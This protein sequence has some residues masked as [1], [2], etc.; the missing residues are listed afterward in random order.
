VRRL[1]SSPRKRRRAAWAGVLL[2][3][4]GC[5]VLIGFLWPNTG[6][7]EA[8]F[9][10]GKPKIV[11]EEPPS[12]PL[13]KADLAS[14]RKV[15]DVFVAE[16][17]L[18]QHLDRA[19]DIVTPQ[20]RQGMTRIEWKTQDNP[21]IPFPVRDFVLAKSKL[22]YSHGNIARYDVAMLARPQGQTA[23]GIFSIELHALGR[24][25][26]RHWL[27][28][29]W[30]PIGGGISTPAV[31]RANPLALRNQT[32]ATAQPLS[33]SWVLVPLAVLSLIVLLPVGLGVRGWVRNRRI[34]RAYE[35]KTLPPLKK[36][37]GS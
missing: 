37:T 6:T 3:A 12:S 18:R 24:D 33:T 36:P 16:A 27:V 13:S 26:R 7:K 4:A 1:L 20:M 11:H 34:N 32:S 21:V 23:S 29:Y 22:S 10:P 30:Q 14:S 35:A 31:P 5:A 17:V 28:D 25:G 2:A 19:Y 8:E 9:Q 15:V